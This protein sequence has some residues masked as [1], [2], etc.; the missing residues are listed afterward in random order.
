MRGRV[1]LLVRRAAKQKVVA[2]GLRQR[3]TDARRMGLL[4][5]HGGAGGGFRFGETRH[6]GRAQTGTGCARPGGGNG[7]NLVVFGAEQQH[8]HRYDGDQHQPCEQ[9]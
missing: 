7:D 3:R 2:S 6:S 4:R 5:V 1:E 9:G 8:E